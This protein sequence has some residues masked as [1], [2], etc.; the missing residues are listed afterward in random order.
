M[1]PFCKCGDESLSLA[2]AITFYNM[3][4]QYIPEDEVTNSEEEV[5]EEYCAED[6]WS[7]G[8]E[9]FE[10]GKYAEAIICFAKAIQIQPENEENRRIFAV[11]A[12]RLNSNISNYMAKLAAEHCSGIGDDSLVSDDGFDYAIENYTEAIK[13]E[14][15]NAKYL[16]KRGEAYLQH[17]EYEKAITD[18]TEAIRRNS[19]D[20]IS[21]ANRAKDYRELGDEEKALNGSNSK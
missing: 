3:V 2:E 9:F 19:D 16:C 14:P 15:E 18:F 21:Y 10:D 7:H 13:L 8:F 17:I 6:S 4:F 20:T 5:N 11:T 12:C 1:F